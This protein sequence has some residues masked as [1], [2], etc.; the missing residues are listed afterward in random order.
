L[1]LLVAVSRTSLSQVATG[2]H[3]TPTPV[4]RRPEIVVASIDGVIARRV[5]KYIPCACVGLRAKKQPHGRAI[6]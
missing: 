6:T 1:A 2:S 3:P 5:I 4:Q